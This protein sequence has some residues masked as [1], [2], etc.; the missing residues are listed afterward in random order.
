METTRRTFNLKEKQAILSN[1]NEWNLSY[2]AERFRVSL[3]DIVSVESERDKIDELTC[4]DYF[5]AG[6]AM[7]TR[8]G[9]SP[10]MENILYAWFMRESKTHKI[11]N[12]I[13]KEKALEIHRIVNDL[14]S[15]LWLTRGREQKLHA[16]ILLPQIILL[17]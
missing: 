9:N 16:V 10:R 3:Q 5:K 7:D 17:P 14:I 13:I 8:T 11:T 1:P 2:M 15:T 6:E 4:S 12:Q